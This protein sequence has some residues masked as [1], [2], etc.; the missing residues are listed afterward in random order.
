MEYRVAN[1]S[2]IKM[3]DVPQQQHNS[4]V[5]RLGRVYGTTENQALSKKWVA[6]GS[7][8]AHALV[9]RCTLMVVLPGELYQL[10][11]DLEFSR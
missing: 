2:L 6:I 3:N 11:L 1:D 8:S 5:T 4:F 7:G 10:L 9:V